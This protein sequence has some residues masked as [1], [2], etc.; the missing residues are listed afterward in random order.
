MSVDVKICGITTPEQALM[1]QSA[2]ADALGLVL[3]E[4]SSR[5]IDLQQAIAIRAA[6]A[7]DRLCVVL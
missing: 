1:V 5:Y 4:K 6:I 7:P 3:Y 2:G